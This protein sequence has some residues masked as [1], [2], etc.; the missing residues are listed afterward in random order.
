MLRGKSEQKVGHL[1]LQ[2]RRKLGIGDLPTDPQ[3]HDAAKRD[4][5]TQSKTRSARF[6]VN[7]LQ[8]IETSERLEPQVA[9]VLEKLF[10]MLLVTNHHE[11]GAD[12]TV[13]R[14]PFEPNLRA[15]CGHHKDSVDGIACLIRFRIPGMDVFENAHRQRANHARLVAK[16]VEGGREADARRIAQIAHRKIGRVAAVQDARRRIQHSVASQR[17]SAALE[18]RR[19]RGWAAHDR[20]ESRGQ[21][22]TTDRP[23]VA[24]VRGL[25]FH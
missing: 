14:R 6:P 7:E 17:A 2:Q 12:V 21:P 4:R 11:R 16:V 13:D 22:D 20:R 25:F 10:R 18:R 9:R 19:P 24:K 23:I 15:G 5:E 3:S 1:C 8:S